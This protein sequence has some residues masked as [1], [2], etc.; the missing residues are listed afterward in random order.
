MAKMQEEGIKVR[1]E[2]RNKIKEYILFQD[3]YAIARHTNWA[4]S[5]IAAMK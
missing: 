4:L 3:V 5:F 1:L 2:S